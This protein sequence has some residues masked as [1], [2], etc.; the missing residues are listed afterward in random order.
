MNKNIPNGIILI[1][2]INFLIACGCLW[3]FF[4]AYDSILPPEATTVNVLF[5]PLLFI[6]AVGILFLKNWARRLV[7]V[8]SFL[9]ILNILYF[10]LILALLLGIGPGGYSGYEDFLMSPMFLGGF[11]VFLGILFVPVVL[12][13]KLIKYLCRPDIKKNFT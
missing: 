11:L 12:Y 3:L 9:P 2:A 5:T 6:G 1:A 7:M 10:G 8:T 4:Y 13:V